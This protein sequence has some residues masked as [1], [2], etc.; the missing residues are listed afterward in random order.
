MQDKEGRPV[1]NKGGRHEEENFSCHPSTNSCGFR[2]EPDR[3]EHTHDSADSTYRES[4]CY[5][6]HTMDGDDGESDRNILSKG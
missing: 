1:E 2:A 6:P 5:S 3:G 4:Q